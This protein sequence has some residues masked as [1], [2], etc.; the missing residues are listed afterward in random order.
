M[1]FSQFEMET[2]YRD[3]YNYPE[4]SQLIKHLTLKLRNQPV[5]FLARLI[6]LVVTRNM[7]TLNGSVENTHFFKILLVQACG[8]EGSKKFANLTTIPSAWSYS[9]IYDRLLHKLRYSLKDITL[10][11]RG[12]YYDPVSKWQTLSRL[13]KMAQLQTLTFNSYVHDIKTAESILRNCGHLEQLTI[14]MVFQDLFRGETDINQWITNNTQQHNTLKAL[15]IRIDRTFN[16]YF[17]DYLMYKY[18]DIESI[19][20]EKTNINEPWGTYWVNPLDIASIKSILVKIKR[21]PS[22]TLTCKALESEVNDII[23]TLISNGHA[24][25][26]TYQDIHTSILTVTNSHS[27]HSNQCSSFHS[28]P[29]PPPL[30]MCCPF[31]LGGSIGLLQK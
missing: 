27:N 4:K 18:P 23:N 22:Y 21:V 9:N 20:V 14:R 30:M 29:T 2:T 12:I 6:P 24:V 19:L 26:K 17:I 28:T 8:D 7:E 25:S 1:Q 15:R 3:S 11:F 16:P 10:N 5:D 31:E 13:N